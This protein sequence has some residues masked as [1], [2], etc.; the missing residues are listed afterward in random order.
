[1]DPL[2]QAS[3]GAAAAAALS[4]PGTVRAALLVGALAGAAPDLDVFIRSREDPL[5]G[6]EYHRHFTH[7]VFLAPLIG[8]LV[9]LLVR[10]A[11]YRR[12][13]AVFGLVP[14]GIAGALT[15]GLIDA[16]TSYGTLLYWPLLNHRESWDVISIIDP[17]F[18]GPIVVL[19]LGALV[20]H[21]PALARAALVLGL[22]Y[23]GL[24]LVQRERAQAYAGQLAEARGHQP[25]ALTARPSLGNLLLWRLVYRAGARYHVDAVWLG[26]FGGTRHYA[27]GSA[28]AFTAVDALAVAP[29]D[30]VL[31]R[32]IERFR[33]FSQDYLYRYADDPR[34]VG[35]LRYALFP[36]ST[37]PLWGIRVN[38]GRPGEHVSF[39]YFR[40]A[41]RAAFDR[42]WRMI[43]GL[44]VERLQ[45][46][47]KGLKLSSDGQSYEDETRASGIH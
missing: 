14:F 27:G 32:D 20:R 44:P 4:R 18:T 35:D 16:C 13:F 7:S 19:L 26:P 1:M 38:P 23:L 40:E 31:H 25:E 45:S 15:H 6:L 29:E 42:L 17:L 2:T 10:W 46:E 5:L 43:R 24:G 34:V 47:R 8:A 37:K 33:F 3:V 41:S 22:V 28:F 39:E 12:R 11:C 36:D 9:G 21:R 30:S